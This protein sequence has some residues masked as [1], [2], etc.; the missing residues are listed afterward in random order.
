MQG[1]EGNVK[2]VKSQMSRK[3]NQ[4]FIEIQNLK[5]RELSTAKKQLIELQIKRRL[6]NGFPNEAKRP[7]RKR[8]KPDSD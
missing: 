1:Y 4:L 8:K 6:L 5:G 3:I 7:V 2:S